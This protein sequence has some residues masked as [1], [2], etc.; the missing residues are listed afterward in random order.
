MGWTF[1]TA[2]RRMTTVIAGLV[3]T[4]IILSVGAVSTAIFATLHQQSIESGRVQ[5]QANLR[6]AATILER[7]FTNVR[8]MWSEDG[9]L[10][11]FKLFSFPNMTDNEPVEAVTNVTGQDVSIFEFNAE[12]GEL[13][14]R[15]TSLDGGADAADAADLRLGAESPATAALMAGESFVGEIP[16]L[17]TS[18]YGALVPMTNLKG[19]LLGAIQVMTPTAAIEARANAVLLPIAITGG[20]AIVV[21][22]LFGLLVSRQLTR[23]IPRL[24]GVMRRIADGDFETDVPFADDGSEIGEMARAVQV[25]RESAVRVRNMTEAEAAR[26][27]DEEDRR[28]AMMTQLQEAF[29]VV[30]EAALDGD[31]TKR[32]DTKF[33][34]RELNTLAGSI[35]ELV[36]GFARGMEELTRVLAAMARADL[37]DRM[38]GTQRGAC[39][40]L[41][42][43]VNVLADKFGAIV[44][45]LKSASSQLKSATGEILAGASDLSARTTRQAATIEEASASTEQLAGIVVENAER[46]T[47]ATR[48]AT[49]V[50]ETAIKSADAMRA[51][52]E[53]MERIRTSS[54]KISNIIGLIDDIAF[55]T[56]LLALN[57]SVEAARAGDAGRGFA[58]VA[59][60]VRRLAQSAAKASADVKTLVEQASTEVVAGSRLVDDA[61]KGIETMRQSARANQTLLDAIASNSR[62]QATAIEG[63][64]DAMRQLDEMTQRNAALVEE[65]NAAIEQTGGQAAALD[66]IV[67]VFSVAAPAQR[68]SKQRTGARSYAADGKAAVA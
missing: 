8:L 4:S 28:Q 45:E 64:N 39:A 33:A 60:E 42:D 20:T 57:A 55:Q 36:E 24:A 7:S 68:D 9:M 5:Q 18:Y 62:E 13:V 21:L 61:T 29:G 27:L 63:L 22:G 37:A 48:N 52:D 66:G 31:F 38:V 10:E 23:P 6:I 43:S 53:A 35:N 15:L 34:D 56:N 51:A 40:A 49:M 12:T 11:A 47:E 65:T 17:G 58:V 25:L 2:G 14:A 50:T 41:S 59:V 19:D 3:I 54:G 1:R 46:A 30:V 44:G 26:I 16:L 67:S 32:V